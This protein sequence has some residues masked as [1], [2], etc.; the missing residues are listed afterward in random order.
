ME[1][2][3]E[4]EPLHGAQK[5]QRGS[6]C[7]GSV[8]VLV[9]SQPLPAIDPL[10]PRYSFHNI[11][12]I[13]RPRLAFDNGLLPTRAPT[14]VFFLFMIG[15]S[16]SRSCDAAEMPRSGADGVG[17]SLDLIKS[18]LNK[19]VVQRLAARLW[20]KKKRKEKS[21]CAVRQLPRLQSHS[22]ILTSSH[23]KLKPAIALRCA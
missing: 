18:E 20:K 19:S 13:P 4:R 3:K 21:K 2:E 1:R 22:S 11:S 15:E 23:Q 17:H 6:A 14:G 7:A 12:W 10:E 5:Q 16:R 9:R 8:G